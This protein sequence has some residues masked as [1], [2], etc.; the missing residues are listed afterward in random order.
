MNF[1]RRVW[2][3]H[4][5]SEEMHKWGINQKIKNR[6]IKDLKEQIYK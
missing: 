4:D 2:W 6:L 5:P 1:L 3:N